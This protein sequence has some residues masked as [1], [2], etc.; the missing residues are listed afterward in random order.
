MYQSAFGLYEA[1]YLYKAK[2]MENGD[3]V[4]GAL[5]GC[6]PFFYIATVEAMK[7]MCVDELNDGKVENL[8]LTR[9]LDWSI[10]KLS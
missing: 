8:K 10:E 7:E 5:L 1:K 2:S 9:V 3:E 4:V 6:S